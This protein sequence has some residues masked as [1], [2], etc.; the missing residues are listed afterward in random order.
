MVKTDPFIIISPLPHMPQAKLMLQYSQP[1]SLHPVI[2]KFTESSLLQSLSHYR[3]FLCL[4]FAQMRMK[5]Y[6]L[7]ILTSPSEEPMGELS[8]KS[9]GAMTST[10]LTASSLSSRHSC[11]IASRMMRGGSLPAM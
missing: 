3:S 5:T 2:R 1:C 7:V 10:R 9:G 6:K 11:S 4:I 8:I